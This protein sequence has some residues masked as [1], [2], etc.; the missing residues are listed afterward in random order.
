VK[1]ETLN[2]RRRASA[3]RQRKG[4]DFTGCRPSAGQ[5]GFLL[6]VYTHVHRAAAWTAEEPQQRNRISY[7]NLCRLI[8]ASV[9]LT[10]YYDSHGYMED[11]QT[12]L[13]T[14]SSRLQH[15]P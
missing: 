9:G 3:N 8:D 10:S 12:L 15:Q 2:N 7:L 11:H 13:V 6:L 5:H 1:Y 14:A 4:K